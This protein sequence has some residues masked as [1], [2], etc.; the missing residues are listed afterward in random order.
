MTQ[1]LLLNTWIFMIPVSSRVSEYLL[2]G[3]R[4][5]AANMLAAVFITMLLGVLAIGLLG[6]LFRFHLYLC[7][8][9]V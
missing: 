7:M 5:P 2:F 9:G 3:K 1:C 6:N 4:L 8:S